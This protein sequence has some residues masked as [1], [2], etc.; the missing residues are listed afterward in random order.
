[1]LVP[2]VVASGAPHPWLHDVFPWI[3]MFKAGEREREREMRKYK[4][5]M[6]L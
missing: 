4:R 1:V 6:D 2:F 5:C 3:F